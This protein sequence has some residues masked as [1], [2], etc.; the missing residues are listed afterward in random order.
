MRAMIAEDVFCSGVFE[1]VKKANASDTGC[2]SNL[3]LGVHAFELTGAI[4][5]INSS[6]WSLKRKKANLPWI[7]AQSSARLVHDQIF[8]YP[9]PSDPVF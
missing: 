8:F 7:K 5:R 3:L 6:F 1:G 9:S 4:E 2:G